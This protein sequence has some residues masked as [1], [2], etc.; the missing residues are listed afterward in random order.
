MTNVE[1]IK[2][3]LIK[4]IPSFK[5]V[6]NY[7]WE[8]S[9]FNALTIFFLDKIKDDDSI[10][11]QNTELNNYFQ[12]II[13][14]LSSKDEVLNSVAYTEGVEIINSNSKFSDLFSEYKKINISSFIK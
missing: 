2:D 3:K 13:D 4:S 8:Y 7:D 6:N 10:N 9:L 14:L 11:L 5:D 1:L 12:L